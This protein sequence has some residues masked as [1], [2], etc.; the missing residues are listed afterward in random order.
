M[1]P[2]PEGDMGLITIDGVGVYGADRHGA[3]GFG[4]Q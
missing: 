4:T 3:R 1:Q 2:H